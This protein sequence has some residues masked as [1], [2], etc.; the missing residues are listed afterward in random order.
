MHTAAAA[1]RGGIARALLS[2]LLAV[3]RSR[4]YQRVSLE[5]GSQDAFAP[6]RSLYAGAG[7]L[8]CEAFGDYPPSEH[9]VFMTL[10]F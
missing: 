2:H 8:A 4:G 1:R 3:A 5:T 6:A 9:S 7:F 10:L